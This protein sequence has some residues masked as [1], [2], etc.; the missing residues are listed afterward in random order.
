M[1]NGARV[2]P[3]EIVNAYEA[4]ETHPK[5]QVSD[6]VIDG[7][8]AAV[9]RG[10]VRVIGERVVVRN[11]RCTMVG[12]PQSDIR[13]L[14]FGLHVR[15]GQHIQV[16]NSVFSG[17]QWA[18]SG[19]AYW[20]GDGVSVERNVSDISLTD[21]TA[22][23]NTDAGFDIKSWARLDRVSASGN[24]RNFRFWAG[25]EVG[26]MTVGEV[27]KRGGSSSCMGVWVGGGKHGVPPRLT[28][29]TLVVRMREPADIIRVE[30]GP[31]SISI[32][33]CD[34][35]APRSAKLLRLTAASQVTLG[36]TCRGYKVVTTRAAKQD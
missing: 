5:A 1:V 17:F 7:V 21:V 9:Q 13:N 36:P 8:N 2:G 28:I 18:G 33:R 31:A 10:C 32:A 14:P 12:G 29:E 16:E 6:L 23:N 35:Q 3:V 24:C 15:G 30:G 25:A 26:T 4:V 34:I 11:L 20:N 22:D 27:V 19:N